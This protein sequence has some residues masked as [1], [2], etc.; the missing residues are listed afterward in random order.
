MAKFDDIFKDRLDGLEETLPE[1]DFLEFRQALDASRAERP[2][3]AVPGWLLYGVPVA[4]AA[5]CGTLVLTLDHARPEKTAPVDPVAEVVKAEDVQVEESLVGGAARQLLAEVRERPSDETADPVAPAYPVVPADPVV[6]EE[7]GVKE[8]AV[9]PAV[10]VESIVSVEPVE[11]ESEVGEVE[12]AVAEDD[13]YVASVEDVGEE[14]VAAFDPEYSPYTKKSPV[15]IVVPAVSV[16]G[17][18]VAALMTAVTGNALREPEEGIPPSYYNTKSW[19]GNSQYFYNNGYPDGVDLQIKYF[20][21]FVAGLSLR[22]PVAGNWS[23]VTG[24]DYA[25]YRTKVENDIYKYHCIGVPLRMDYTFLRPGRFDLYAGA[26]A[27]VEWCIGQGGCPDF[28]LLATCGVQYDFTEWLGLYVEPD[29]LWAFK[30]DKPFIFTV[31][32]GLRF[33]L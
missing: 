19:Y 7:V 26:G 6:S 2:K 4:A 24:L 13:D 10:S 28:S 32:C 29:L 33:N 23:F 12:A 17:T 15:K 8:E 11:S 21:P 25:L 20:S 30:R 31:G 27:K 3:H 22:V 9:E 16:A 5:V 18:G 1:G 14:E